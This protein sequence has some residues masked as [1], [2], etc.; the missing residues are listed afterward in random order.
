MSKGEIG[1]FVLLAGSIG[2]GLYRLVMDP[3]SEVTP[4]IQNKNVNAAASPTTKRNVPGAF[5]LEVTKDVNAT[6]KN[7]IH[8]GVT[9]IQFGDTK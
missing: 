1:V 8:D 3:W 7:D 9:D 4:L 2:A 5:V 6:K